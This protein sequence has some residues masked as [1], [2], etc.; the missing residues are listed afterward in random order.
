MVKDGFFF[1]VLKGINIMKRNF[2]RLFWVIG[3]LSAFITALSITASAEANGTCGENLT[4]MLDDNGTLTISG[5]GEMQYNDNSWLPFAPWYNIRESITTVEIDSGVTS[6]MRGAFYECRNLTSITIPAGITNIGNDYLVF[7]GCTSLAEINV[8]ENNDNYSSLNGVLFNKDRNELIKYPEGKSGNYIIPVSVTSIGSRSFFGCFGVTSITLPESVVEIGDRAFYECSGLKEVHYNGSFDNFKK[9]SVG[10]YNECYNKATIYCTDITIMGYGTC[11]DNLTWILYDDGKLVISGT[12]DMTNYSNSSSSYY[13]PFY[14]N[15]NIKSVI[16]ENSITGIGDKA[17]SGCNGLTSVKIPN[18][19]TS[20]GES[21]FSGCDHLTSIMIPTGVT[22]IGNSAFNGC[23]NLESIAVAEDNQNYAAENN[24]LFNKEKTE[25]IKIAGKSISGTYTV[26][27]GVISIGNLAFSGCYDLTCITIPDSVTSIGNL[28]F[29]DCENLTIITIP[30][31]ITS[32]GYNAFDQS[33]KELHYDGSFENF[34]KIYPNYH[35]YCYIHTIIYCTDRTVEGYGFCGGTVFN[36]EDNLT[37]VRENG[38]LTIEGIGTMYNNYYPNYQGAQAPW[39][40]SN[41]KNIIIK[42]GVTSIGRYAFCDCKDLSSVTIPDTVTKIGNYAFDRCNSFTDVYYNGLKEQWKQI[43][44]DNENDYL[45]YA[46]IHCNDG[47]ISP[48]PM[49]MITAE[50]T[51]IDSTVDKKY[52]FTVTLDETL[53][54]IYERCKVYAAVYDK[55]GRLIDFNCVGL[56]T[57]FQTTISVNKSDNDAYAK[58]F[59]FQDT[60]QP[61]LRN[62]EKIALQ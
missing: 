16:L 4:W 45:T 49:P 54:E 33:L 31:S 1:Y 41:I 17:F 57:Y 14:D 10:E 5:T 34:R 38:I 24:V 42:N 40:G 61:I 21:A 11:G 32:I 15:D 48:P 18:S 51:R 27:D 52:V 7:E 26:P 58:I 47:I 53:N 23:D 50:I 20:I 39:Q 9:I 8:D 56:N 59:I 3:V 60:L 44:I 2:L 62:V 46:S 25:L 19:V 29:Y 37:W 43:T 22:E 12:G 30:D 13:S 6:I 36:P 35:E 28:A 55:K